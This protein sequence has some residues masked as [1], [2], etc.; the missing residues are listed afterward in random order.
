MTNPNEVEASVET[1]VDSEVLS[2]QE[3]LA[4]L[5]E[6]MQALQKT[7]SE[8]RE[9]QLNT[10]RAEVTGLIRD[11]ILQVLTEDVWDLISGAGATGVMVTRSTSDTVGEPAVT[12][13]VLVAASSSKPRASSG[14]SNGSK[15]DLDG[16]IATYGTPAEKAMIAGMES[17][18]KSKG[19][20][21]QKKSKIASDHGYPM[22]TG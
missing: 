14:A 13:L 16:I 22:K 18:G 1:S 20:I 8:E 3:Q 4:V 15:R 17:E 5:S 19:A 12:S 6:K 11:E 10:K 2:L 9:S 21:W 7:Q